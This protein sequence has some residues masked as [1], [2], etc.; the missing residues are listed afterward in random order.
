[1]RFEASVQSSANFLEAEISCAPI[2]ATGLARHLL[3]VFEIDHAE[4]P[5]K[6]QP[7]S[8]VLHSMS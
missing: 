3:L 2:M 6:E 5:P 8:I 7:K 1:M 4:M